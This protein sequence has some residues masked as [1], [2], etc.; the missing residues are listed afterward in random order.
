MLKMGFLHGDI[1]IGNVLMLDLPVTKPSGAWTMEQ[2]VTQLRFQDGGEPVAKHVSLLEQT[3]RGL[4]SPG[5]CHG[6]VVDGDM[7]ARLK[8]SLTAAFNDGA[9]RRKHDRDGVREFRE[10][11][12]GD[13]RLFAVHDVRL[14][15]PGFWEEDEY[16]AF[17]A[18][19]VALLHPWL[20]KLDILKADWSRVMYQAEDLEDTK[21]REHLTDNFL[22]YGY[23]GVAEYFQLLHQHRE[24]LEEAV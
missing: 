21:M 8:D 20:G 5:K 13:K 11:I 12:S 9:R 18:D 10:M 4:D 19:S 16:G 15:Y 22:A 24:S 17:F 1:N 14:E 7:S 3:I 6:F 2:L 23:R